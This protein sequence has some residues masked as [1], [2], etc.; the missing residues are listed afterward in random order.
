MSYLHS[1][2]QK[3]SRVS[4][5]ASQLRKL[6]IKDLLQSEISFLSSLIFLIQRYQTPLELLSK[7]E[8][9]ILSSKEVTQ[10]FGNIEQIKD[11]SKK[12]VVEINQQKQVGKVFIDAV[13]EHFFH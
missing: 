1:S 7:T 13:G 12:L 6:A 9:A 10:L 11:L 8:R 2:V 4:T 5:E 3:S